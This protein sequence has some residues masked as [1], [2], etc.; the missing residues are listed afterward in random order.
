MCFLQG[1]ATHALEKGDIDEATEVLD[2]LNKSLS[3]CD[4]CLF[5][6]QNFVSHLFAR[7][8]AFFQ[9]R[10]FVRLISLCFLYIQFLM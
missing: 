6:I 10:A 3:F 4:L 5:L 7:I 1:L 8:S 9:R 2:L